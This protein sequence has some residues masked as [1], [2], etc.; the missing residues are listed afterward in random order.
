MPLSNVVLQATL[1]RTDMEDEIAWGT[2]NNINL[3]ET[4]HQGIELSASYTHDHFALDVYYTWMQSEFTAGANKGNEIP[5]VPQNQ[6]DLNLAL[7]LTDAL[8]FNTHMS[9]VGSMF[10][11]GD[12]DNSGENKQSEYAIFDLL[13]EYDLPTAKVDSTVFA[14]ID[15]VFAT[16]YNYL[17][18]WGGY[19]PAPERTFKA[20]LS[21]TF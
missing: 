13:L 16:E 17:V 15:N 20:G 2:T 14:G 12:N 1:F 18:S 10:E 4:T 19:Y 8:T 7:F 9:Y 6:L 3:D 5:W 11:S 21:V